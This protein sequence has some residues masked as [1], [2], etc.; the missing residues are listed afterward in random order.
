MQKLSPFI[1]FNNVVGSAKLN[2]FEGYISL[3]F[4]YSHFKFRNANIVTK[5]IWY[6]NLAVM[7][8]RQNRKIIHR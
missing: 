3:G 1:P 6:K 4:N 5:I 2:Y 8:E 7:V